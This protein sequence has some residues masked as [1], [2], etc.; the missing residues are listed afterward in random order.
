MRRIERS[1]LAS[2]LATTLGLSAPMA[3]A[4]DE[5]ESATP[6]ATHEPDN[7]GVNE[8]DRDGATK[9]PMDQSNAPADVSATRHIRQS[10]ADDDSLGVNAR[11]VKIITNGG[12]VTLRGPVETASEREA[13]ERIARGTQGV[14]QVHNEIEVESSAPEEER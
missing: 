3:L 12:V 2:V 13:I 9:T 10:I 11:N 4:A 1:L 5:G 6:S 8:R 7:T 14:T